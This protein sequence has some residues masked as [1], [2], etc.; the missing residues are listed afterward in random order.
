[1]PENPKGILYPDLDSNPHLGLDLDLGNA[2]IQ[3]AARGSLGEPAPLSRPHR[4]QAAASAGESRSTSLAAPA[5]GHSSRHG[6]AATAS[7][8]AA[9]ASPRA[10]AYA[11]SPACAPPPATASHPAQQQQLARGSGGAV[12]AVAGPADEVACGT[13]D[14]GLLEEERARGGGHRRDRSHSRRGPATAARP[15]SPPQ[16]PRSR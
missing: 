6:Q 8:Q 3:V 5:S 1:M 12:L 16:S 10:H 7:G 2:R 9:T 13:S 11:P 14:P 15:Y 4:P